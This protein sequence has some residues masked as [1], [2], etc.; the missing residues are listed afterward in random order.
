LFDPNEL[1]QYIVNFENKTSKKTLERL[2]ID[3]IIKHY[4]KIYKANFVNKSFIKFLLEN[5]KF[6]QEELIDYHPTELGH[7]LWAEFLQNK[8]NEKL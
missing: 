3:N 2:E 8:V 4:H 6:K 1:Q 5:N 7:Q